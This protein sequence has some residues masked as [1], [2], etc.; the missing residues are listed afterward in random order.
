MRRLLP[1]TLALASLPALAGEAAPASPP[2]P[3][4]EV[5]RL[6]IRD[7]GLDLGT[8]RLDDDQA[9]AT[10]VLLRRDPDKAVRRHLRRAPDLEGSLLF[11]VKMHHGRVDQVRLVQDTAGDTEL[12]LK[13]AKRLKKAKAGPD[14]TAEVFLPVEVRAPVVASAE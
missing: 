8:K 4:A 14:I 6:I 13:V 5:A 2:D 1:L 9:I 12:A 3:R 11:A 7:A 10:A